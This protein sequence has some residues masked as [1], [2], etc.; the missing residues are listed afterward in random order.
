MKKVFF[1]LLVIAALSSCSQEEVVDT[2]AKTPISFGNVFVEKSTQSRAGEENTQKPTDHT[3][4]AGGDLTQF[5]VYGRVEGNIDNA[6]I[7]T[8]NKVTGEIGGEWI[9]EGSTQ[10][11]IPGATFH[12]T[13]WAGVE[14]SDIDG[15]MS[16]T[17]NVENQNDLLFAT[18][19]RT[20]NGQSTDYDKVDFIFDHVLTKVQF[21]FVNNYA[22]NSNVALTVKNIQITNAITAAIYSNGTNK[23]YE[24]KMSWTNHDKTP[25]IISFGETGSIQPGGNSGYCGNIGLL[26]PYTYSS[27]EKLN[28]SFDVYHNGKGITKNTNV[29]IDLKE[30]NSYNFTAELDAKSVQGVMPITFSI[31]RDEN[32][33]EKSYNANL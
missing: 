30:G 22:A 7:Y 25:A 6:D 33:D 5:Q 31:T 14:E 4:G 18:Y 16:V 12:F 1:T 28:V 21:T 15:P 20:L 9:C 2:V 3:Y 8:G 24:G 32:W 17:Y 11:W 23:P 29:E 19:N 13:A 10:Y 27:E 26:I